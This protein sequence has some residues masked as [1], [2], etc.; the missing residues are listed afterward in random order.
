MD[1]DPN[2]IRNGLI[3]FIL[4]V[5]SISFHE[6]GHAIVADMPGGRHASRTAAS[7]SIPWCTS[8][9]SGR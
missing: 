5:A 9:C 7:R 4:L 3:T 2:F 1:I 6:W 8:T